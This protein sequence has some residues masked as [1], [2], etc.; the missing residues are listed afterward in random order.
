MMIK[1]SNRFV[2]RCLY[3]HVYVCHSLILMLPIIN[4]FDLCTYMCVYIVMSLLISMLDEEIVSVCH[5]NIKYQELQVNPGQF[6]M[7]IFI[8]PM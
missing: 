6:V 8:K 7:Y 3:A 4:P 2:I 1:D 5:I